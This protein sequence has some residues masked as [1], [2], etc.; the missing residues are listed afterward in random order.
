VP[1]EDRAVPHT[2]QGE[3]V[4]PGLVGD[5][6]REGGAPDRFAGVAVQSYRKDAVARAVDR[7]LLSSAGDVGRFVALVLQGLDLAPLRRLEGR[8]LPGL[9]AAGERRPA[10]VGGGV[11]VRL[12]GVGESGAEPDVPEQPG[13]STSAMTKGPSQ[14]GVSLWR[15]L[16]LCLSLS[17]KSPTLKDRPR[18]HRVW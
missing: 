4:Q 14:G 5:G 11:G 2:E 16:L 7:V 18:T 13:R 15:P 10:G 1:D 3:V 6:G 8:R 17:T 12:L 9:P